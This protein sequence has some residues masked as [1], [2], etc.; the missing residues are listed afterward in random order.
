MAAACYQAITP[1]QNNNQSDAAV[2]PP[3]SSPPP[4]P[5]ASPPPQTCSNEI[6]VDPGFEQPGEWDVTGLAQ[7]QPTADGCQDPGAAVF[8]FEARCTGGTVHQLMWPCQ[9]SHPAQ[10]TISTTLR[11]DGPNP[12]PM[13]EMMLGANVMAVGINGGWHP[14]EVH[15]PHEWQTHTLCLGERAQTQLLDLTISPFGGWHITD[16]CGDTSMPSPSVVLDNVSVEQAPAGRCPDPGVVVNGDFENGTAGWTLDGDAETLP[17]AGQNGSTALH[18]WSQTENGGG[19]AEQNISYP[20]SGSLPSPALQFWMDGQ[21]GSYVFVGTGLFGGLAEFKVAGQPTVHRICVPRWLQGTVR[22]LTFYLSVDM[23]CGISDPPCVQD[24]V[25]DD[26]SLVSEPTCTDANILD[27][28]FELQAANPDI[29]HGWYFFH[30][31]PL[32]AGEFLTDP[33]QAHTGQ[34]SVKL[35]VSRQCYAARLHN[36]YRVPEPQGNA[37][38]VLR[39]W[40]RTVS[41]LNAAAVLTADTGDP[42]THMTALP[43]TTNW[44]QQSVCLNPNAAT[45]MRDIDIEITAV[46]GNCQVDFPTEAV[47]LDDFEVGTDPSCPPN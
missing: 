33:Q 30:R 22:Q 11:C 35:T 36:V 18:L 45:Q 5:D 29:R 27:G 15:V 4:G 46:G 13:C 23:Y 7:I 17:G 3:D 16:G 20:M 1:P 43:S 25:I 26:V 34:G 21:P 37:G 41:F 31:S 38:P 14:V 40:Y 9:L 24:V 8:S 19:Q 12:D 39:F 2:Q 42:M 6:P 47:W 32:A 28:G 44:V 10:L